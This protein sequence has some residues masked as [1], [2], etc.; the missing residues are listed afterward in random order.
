MADSSLYSLHINTVSGMILFATFL[1][2][3]NKSL[4]TNVHIVLSLKYSR[5]L[6]GQFI[7]VSSI[8]ERCIYLTDVIVKALE[9]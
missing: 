6:H 3:K 5:M 9:I 2:L 8:L 7:K 4:I 1:L